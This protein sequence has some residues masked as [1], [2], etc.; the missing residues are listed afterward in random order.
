MLPAS[1]KQKKIQG[2]AK[3]I[4]HFPSSSFRLPPSGY[5][6]NSDASSSSPKKICKNKK[7][8]KSGKELPRQATLEITDSQEIDVLMD[9]IGMPKSAKNKVTFYNT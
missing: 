1:E 6:E 3:S 7:A 2:N 4:S 5:C 8:T 9:I